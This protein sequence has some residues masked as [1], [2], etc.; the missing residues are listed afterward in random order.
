MKG[1][2]GDRN[3]ST[4]AFVTADMHHHHVRDACVDRQTGNKFYL[5]A[6]VFSPTEKHVKVFET[7]ASSVAS[8]FSPYKNK[9]K[10]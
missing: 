6:L 3:T 10:H 5:P 7:Y 1:A 2:E 4:R 8:V 9:I